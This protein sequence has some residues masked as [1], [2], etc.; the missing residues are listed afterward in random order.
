ML[1]VWAWRVCGYVFGL[2]FGVGCVGMKG[3]WMC[4]CVLAVASWLQ[5]E[6]CG[7]AGGEI[8]EKIK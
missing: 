8:L 4:V 6:L 2:G 5:A 1:G 3:V 7:G